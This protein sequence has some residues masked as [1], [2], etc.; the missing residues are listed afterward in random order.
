MREPQH[1]PTVEVGEAQE[2]VELSQSHQGFPITND[3]YLG[4]GPHA[5]HVHPRCILSI[6]ISACRM[7]IS[8]IGI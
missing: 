3:L 5:P 6:K 4:Q 1:E 7:R 2:I 8:Q